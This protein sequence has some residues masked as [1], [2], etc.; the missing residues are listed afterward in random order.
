MY[1]VPWLTILKCVD[2]IPIGLVADTTATFI[3]TEPEASPGVMATVLL[4]N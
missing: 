4:K 3:S 2:D 1:M